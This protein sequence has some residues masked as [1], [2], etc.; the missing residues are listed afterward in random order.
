[1]EGVD[2]VALFERFEQ[3]EVVD[4][5]PT[6]AGNHDR[7]S[8]IYSTNRP[9]GFFLQG[10]P[11]LRILVELGFVHQFK[12]GSA[13][14]L[15]PV[16]ASYLGPEVD[17]NMVILTVRVELHL[18][19]VVEV[20]EHAEAVGVERSDGPINGI[21]GGRPNVSVL[22]DDVG[23]NAKPNE[24]GVNLFEG[25]IVLWLEVIV[26]LLGGSWSAQVAKPTRD[27]DAYRES[28]EYVRRYAT[29][30]LVPS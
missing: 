19:V 15:S 22:Q 14:I 16:V 3:L 11:N 7:P 21:K 6:V 28:L 27:V 4:T 29:R 2:E 1:M 8:R 5:A 10:K 26:E 9:N 17:K 25:G 24:G 30:R 20:P 13:M 18:A 23:R 12:H